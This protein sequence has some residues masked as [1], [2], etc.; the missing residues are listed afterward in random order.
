MSVYCFINAS[1][2]CE[3]QLASWIEHTTTSSQDTRHVITPTV[4]QRETN[5]QDKRVLNR[6]TV[7]EETDKIAFAF[8]R[9]SCKTC[10]SLRVDK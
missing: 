2:T 10:Y 3:Y 9:N 8:T 6:Q 7:T 1:P 5:N 4:K